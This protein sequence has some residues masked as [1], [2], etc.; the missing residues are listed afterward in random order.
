MK[1]YIYLYVFI[2]IASLCLGQQSTKYAYINTFVVK[3]DSNSFSNCYITFKIP[4]NHLIFKKNNKSYLSGITFNVE[5]KKNKKRVY[6]KSVAKNIFVEDYKLTSSKV[7]FLEGFLKVV[8]KPGFYDMEST[9]SLNSLKNIIYL[10][11][12]S[13]A[14]GSD[15]LDINI[16]I[17]VNAK[18]S[19]ADGDNSFRLLNYGDIFPYS[20][21]PKM[22]I[23]PSPDT[24]ISILKYSLSQKNKIIISDSIVSTKYSDVEL[25]EHNN[26]LYS[27]IR[28]GSAASKV[29]IIK[30]IE[31]YLDEGK[32]ELNIDFGHDKKRTFNFKVVW[33]NKP[34]VLRN[35]EYSITL[36]K[37][38]WK[39]N[40]IVRLL[41]VNEE[42]QYDSLKSYFKKY[43]PNSSTIFNEVMSEFYTRVDYAIFNFGKTVQ[44]SNALSDMGKIY[45]KY[46]KPFNRERIFSKRNNVM[47]VWKYKKP[48]REFLFIDNSGLGDYTLIE[49]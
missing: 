10:P 35:V 3:S 19:F 12:E 8:L 17:L 39:Q 5:I 21:S 20:P 29:F 30:N 2:S 32:C 28:R 43:D 45:I 26:L 15:S 16:P 47:E 9:L 11:K 49:R 38:I 33:L 48:T 25:V 36:V 34:I 22:I 23:I 7:N 27:Q 6:Y 4:Y 14:V 46:G 44:L 18:K 13:F 42:S 40:N 1:K 24:S 41:D 31:R 37:K